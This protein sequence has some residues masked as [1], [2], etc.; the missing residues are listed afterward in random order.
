[1]NRLKRK[2]RGFGKKMPKSSLPVARKKDIFL[3]QGEDLDELCVAFGVED[4][5]DIQGIVS[6]SLGVDFE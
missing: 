5:Y 6:G 2:G 3:E 4:E 1:M